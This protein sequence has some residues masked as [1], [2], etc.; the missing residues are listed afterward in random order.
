MADLFKK[1]WEEGLKYFSKGATGK[2]IIP[3]LLAYGQQGS[4]PVIPPYANLVFDIEIADVKD[5]P[6][7]VAPIAPVGKPTKPIQ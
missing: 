6:T 7:P 1:R 3:A 5:Q 2:M 4:P